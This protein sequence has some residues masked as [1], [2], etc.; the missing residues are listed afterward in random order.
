MKTKLTHF[1]QTLSLVLIVSLAPP[2]R[3]VEGGLGRPIS[4]ATIMPY[5]GVVPPMPGLAVGV[6]EIYYEGSIGGS[7]N[8]PIGINLALNVNMRASFTPISLLYIWDTPTKHWNFASAVT[9]PVT[10][11]EAEANVTS[12]TRTGRVRDSA[13]G[14]FDLILVPIVASYHFSETEHLSLSLTV[15][16][17]TGDYDK[18]K[19]ANLSTNTWTFIPSVAYTKIFPKPNIELSA[20]WSVN[21]DTE[22]YATGYQNGILSD[23][24][25]MAVKRFKCGAGVGVIG[26]WIQQLTDDGGTTADKLNG[27]SG[28]AFGVGPVLTYSTKV[29]KSHLD[30]NLRW[31]HEFENKNRVEGDLAMLNVTLKF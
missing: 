18:N 31:V 21:F 10:W 3:A 29:G 23:L 11:L 22:N 13:A 16:A 17:A 14:L 8:V 5:A 1:A 25:L 9:F 2:A 4:G 28:R 15:W 7:L 27:F 30:F 6:G 12:G 20:S 19:L 26:S 24:E